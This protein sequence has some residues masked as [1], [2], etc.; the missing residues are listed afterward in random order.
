MAAATICVHR[1]KTGAE[2]LLP[3]LPAVARALAKAIYVAAVQSTLKHA[4]SLSPCARLIKRWPLRSPYD[5]S[6]I[7][8]RSA[9]A[10]VRPFSH[11]CAETHAR[12]PSTGAGHA[13]EANRGHPQAP[14]SGS[15][16]A[17]LRVS[18]EGLR[19][20]LCRC[21]DDDIDVQGTGERRSGTSSSSNEP[22]A[23]RISGSFFMLFSL[24]ALSRDEIGCQ[25]G[26]STA[27]ETL[28]GL[29][30]IGERAFV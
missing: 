29:K 24:A 26:S 25:T 12:L 18:V 30:D 14:R 20:W 16:S 10:N 21:R 8:T 3:P 4:T 27:S 13:D 28:I 23:T 19:K 1:P 11:P 2:F 15:T 6:F 22:W 9:P 7:P 5:I 17:Y